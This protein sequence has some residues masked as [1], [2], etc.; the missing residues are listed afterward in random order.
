MNI[1]L[2]IIKNI[3]SYVHSL[4]LIGNLVFIL[5]YAVISIIFYMFM[6]DLMEKCERKK[7]EIK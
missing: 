3:I 5:C 1:E 2:L 4:S 6:E 7:N